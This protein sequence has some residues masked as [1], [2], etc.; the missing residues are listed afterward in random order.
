MLIQHYMII[1]S[2]AVSFSY[3][4]YTIV[5]GHFGNKGISTC[6]TS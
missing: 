3:E 4:A 2:K 5:T 6:N 1:L